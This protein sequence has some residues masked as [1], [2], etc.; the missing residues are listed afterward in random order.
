MN[1]LGNISAETFLSE[2][3]Q[4]KPLLI[5][6]AFPDF[7]PPV[8]ADDIAGLS[9]EED[10]ESRILIG[11]NSQDNWEVLHGPFSEDTF[12]KLPSEN[13]TLL[14]QAVDQWLPEFAD[15]LQNFNFIPSW[16]LDDIM[17]SFAPKGGSVGPHYDQYDVFLIQAMG[18]RKWQVGPKCKEHSETLPNV[19]VKILKE[20]QVDNEWVLNPGDML[21]LPPAF[22][23]NGVA[24]NDCMTFSIG[25]RAPSESDILQGFT[26]H[27]AST[28]NEDSRY[29][30]QNL[31]NSQTSPAHMDDATFERIRKILESKLN[32]KNELKIWLAQYMTESKYEDLHQPLE[33]TLEWPDISALFEDAQQLTQ[34]ETSRWAYFSQ[35]EEIHLFVNGKQ[36]ELAQTEKTQNLARQLANQRHTDISGL[37]DLIQ[38]ADCQN[39]LLD[40]IN[41]N[42]LYFEG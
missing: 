23:H 5:R 33:D 26:D 32:Q 18:Q 22:A 15:L 7:E 25:F 9:L 40:L 41:E 34:N 31:A 30:D 6:N 17:V 37:S 20:M 29:T 1:I 8:D 42:H 36:Q 10:V 3:W 4:K 35:D 21:Y 2:Y 16:R 28:L 24:Q 38:D 19:P 12:T 27:L 11:D 39:L 13:W 14:V